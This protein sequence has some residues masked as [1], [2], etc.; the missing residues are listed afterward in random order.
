[1]KVLGGQTEKALLLQTS[2]A[3]TGFAPHHYRWY[4]E[5]LPDR[6]MHWS[7]S[8]GWV[9][10]ILKKQKLSFEEL[11][12]SLQKKTKKCV[13]KAQKPREKGQVTPKQVPIIAK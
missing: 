4:L 8:I 2:V 11:I 1:M 3:P 9:P 12:P 10:A 13:L 6:K 7:D 5:V